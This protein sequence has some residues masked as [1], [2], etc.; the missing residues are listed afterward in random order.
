MTYRIC[1]TNMNKITLLDW[2]IWPIHHKLKAVD[3][4]VLD[5][6]DRPKGMHDNTYWRYLA[7]ARCF[8]F[9]TASQ[10]N[11]CNKFKK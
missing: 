2:R 3:M 1:N 6:P 5:A 11:Q 10:T 8:L 7:P 9:C 4:N